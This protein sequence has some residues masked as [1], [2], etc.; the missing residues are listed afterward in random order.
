MKWTVFQ[1]VT[2]QTSKW[3]SGDTKRHQGYL[4]AESAPEWEWISTVE[5]F[6]LLSS[7]SSSQIRTINENEQ[8]HR[9]CSQFKYLDSLAQF[10]INSPEYHFEAGNVLR[11]IQSFG[12]QI[13]SACLAMKVVSCFLHLF[14]LKWFLKEAF[15]DKNWVFLPSGCILW[16]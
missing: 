9:H 7:N 5:S 3:R 13:C 11:S 12:K 10:S 6:W 8:F 14:L 16:F 2:L 4:L 1:T 15:H